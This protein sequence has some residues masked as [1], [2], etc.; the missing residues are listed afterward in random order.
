MALDVATIF[1]NFLMDLFR[2]VI[3]PNG[4]F[5]AIFY[6]GMGLMVLSRLC[7]FAGFWRV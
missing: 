3:Y 4:I 1:V 2:F 7:R 6:I 5:S